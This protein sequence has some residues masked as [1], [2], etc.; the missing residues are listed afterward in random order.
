MIALISRK[1]ATV[2]RISASRGNTLATVD[3]IAAH[4]FNV[5]AV[6]AGF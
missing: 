5:I 3:D 2:V 4:S 6:S 1:R